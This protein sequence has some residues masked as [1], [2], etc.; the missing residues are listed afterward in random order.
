MLKHM[1]E[2]GSCEAVDEEK[3]CVFSEGRAE[4]VD[5]ADVQLK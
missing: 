2:F 5:V 3:N 4:M 1:E